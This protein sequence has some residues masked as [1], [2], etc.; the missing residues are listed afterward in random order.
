MKLC[1]AT[2]WKD[3]N[4]FK[5][6]RKV[7][8]EISLS[9]FVELTAHVPLFFFRARVPL[10]LNSTL[11]FEGAVAISGLRSFAKKFFFLSDH[12]ASMIQFAL[13]SWKLREMARSGLLAMTPVMSFLCTSSR[14]ISSETESRKRHERTWIKRGWRSRR[15]DLMP[16]ETTKNRLMFMEKSCTIIALASPIKC[17][18]PVPFQ[19]RGRTE[20][21]E[22]EDGDCDDDANST[23]LFTPK[24]QQ[25]V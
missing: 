16:V 24:H 25:H 12:E 19:L 9:E 8:T 7:D 1:N 2:R 17:Y 5:L 23:V 22:W 3:K 6:I 21:H 20:C 10:N 14:K 4:L 18:A 13:S 11:A 15:R